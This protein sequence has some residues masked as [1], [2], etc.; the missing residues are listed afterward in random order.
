MPTGLSSGSH[1]RLYSFQVPGKVVY[2]SPRSLLVFLKHFKTQHIKVGSLVSCCIFCGF[3]F[4]VVLSY[5]FPFYV[6][7]W[8]TVMPC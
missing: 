1:V 7:L 8:S 3:I 6:D 5:T 2:R 4:F